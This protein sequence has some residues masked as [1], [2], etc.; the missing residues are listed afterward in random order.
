M[1]I[2]NTSDIVDARIPSLRSVVKKGIAVGVVANLAAV[3]ICWLLVLTLGLI[4]NLSP[5]PLT[6][7]YDP[8]PDHEATIH[9][10]ATL[11]VAS[12]LYTLV[13]A[14][15]VGTMHGILTRRALYR[16]A[17]SAT[18]AKW[19]GCMFGLLVSLIPIAKVFD[20]RPAYAEDTVYV[21]VLMVLF[22]LTGV[23]VGCRAGQRLLC[24]MLDTGGNRPTRATCSFAS[25]PNRRR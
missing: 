16:G 23:G 18:K 21:L 25:P 15:L 13:P 12:Y 6:T 20:T 5:P 7:K 10:V 14:A 1:M 19:L 2:Q 8:P 4:V 17:A 24:W 22:L 9:I 11:I 3:M